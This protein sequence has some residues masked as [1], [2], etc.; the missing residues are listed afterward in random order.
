MRL[1][2]RGTGAAAPSAT[3]RDRDGQ[4][5]RSQRR[6]RLRRTAPAPGA[7]ADSL[8]RHDVDVDVAG[9][10][11]DV[12]GGARRSAMLRRLRRDAPTTIWV[13]LTDRAK[14]STAAGDVVADDRVE[15]AAEV[16]GE[17]AQACDESAGAGRCRRR[18]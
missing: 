3:T 2:R 10:A 13:A 9:V 17:L 12:V 8:V 1:G 5:P 6:G 4:R 7:P 18:A 16:L 15:R 11:H 14:S